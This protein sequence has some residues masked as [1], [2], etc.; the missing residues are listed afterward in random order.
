MQLANKLLNLSTIPI[1]L[2]D[3]QVTMLSVSTYAFDIVLVKNWLGWIT[4]GEGPARSPYP[5]S[6][7]NST[8]EREG[9]RKEGGWLDAVESAQGVTLTSLQT[10]PSPCNY[11]YSHCLSHWYT[12]THYPTHPLP[13]FRIIHP[14]SQLHA[15]NHLRNMMHSLLCRDSP[16]KAPYLPHPSA[17]KDFYEEVVYSSDKATMMSEAQ[18]P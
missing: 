17:V 3:L 9:G 10:S 12:Q 8:E 7:T 5:D 1:R 18:S 15:A 14:W 6:M 4:W 11:N 16:S 13:R 2:G